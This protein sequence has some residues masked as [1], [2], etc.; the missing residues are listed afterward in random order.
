MKAMNALI[1]EPYHLRLEQPSLLRL[2]GRS[3]LGSL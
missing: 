2:H 1:K 3:R